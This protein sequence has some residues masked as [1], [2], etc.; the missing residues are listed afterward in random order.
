[1]RDL[2]IEL[3]STI[4]QDVSATVDLL[5]LRTLSRSY[6]ELVTPRAFS[7][8]HIKNS[9]QSAHNCLQI[10]GTVSLAIHVR[11]VVYDSR[12]NERFRLPPENIG[13]SASIRPRSKESNQRR[14][15]RYC[16]CC[17]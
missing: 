8:L 16:G 12:D 9:I 3:V 11:E 10:I 1:M 14:A 7:K 13:K 17:Q 5:H 6:K 2:P 15:R 4:V